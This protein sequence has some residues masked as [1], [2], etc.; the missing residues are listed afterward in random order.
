[1]YTRPP[2]TRKPFN[3]IKLETVGSITSKKHTEENHEKSTVSKQNYPTNNGWTLA[4]K[5]PRGKHRVAYQFAGFTSERARFLFVVRVIVRPIWRPPSHVQGESLAA[6]SSAKLGGRYWSLFFLFPSAA[7]RPIGDSTETGP[8]ESLSSPHRP[9][10]T[11]TALLGARGAR[12]SK[13]NG[14]HAAPG[15]N[16][17]KKR[18]SLPRHVG[19]NSR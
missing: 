8:L 2:N 15:S 16:E 5:Q 17:E 11:K 14:G 6:R 12:R 7:A 1:M 4:S 3:Y 18:D 10:E 19:F 9:G 13:Q